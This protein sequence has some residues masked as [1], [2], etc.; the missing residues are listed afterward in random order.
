M[1]IFLPLR[2]FK[3]V[4]RDTSLYRKQLPLFRLLGLSSASADR[5]GY[6]TNFCS[7]IKPLHELK[8]SSC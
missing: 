5:I 3:I 7:M 8:I 2:I 1:E 6:I 4:F